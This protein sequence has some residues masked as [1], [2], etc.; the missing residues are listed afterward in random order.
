[1]M[2]QSLQLFLLIILLPFG[3]LFSQSMDIDRLVRLKQRLDVIVQTDTLYGQRL[4][5]SISN[6]G[7]NDFLNTIAKAGEVNL[8]V[9]PDINNPITC[10]FKQIRIIDILF[11]V[12][13]EYDLDV[14]GTGNIISVFR[15]KVPFQ[16]PDLHFVYDSSTHTVSFDFTNAKLVN[17]GR[18]FSEQT[19][20]NLVMPQEIF[21]NSVS[22][23]GKDMKIGDAIQ[24]IATV[25]KLGSHQKNETT[26]SVYPD[27]ENQSSVR[28][29]RRFRA[30][31]LYVDSLKQITAKI[32]NGNIQ[33]IIPEICESL[34]LNYFFT[35][36][37][38]Q[39]TGIYVEKVNFDTFLNVLFTGTGYT[40]REENGIYIFG[41][42]GDNS[43]LS[44]AKVIPMKYRTVEK[45]VDY[46][47]NELKKGIEILTFPDLNSLILSGDHRQILKVYSFLK[48]IDRSVPLI[49]IDVIILDATDNNTREAGLKM[50]L[51]S[52]PSET[53]GSL[54]PGVNFSLSSGS[55]NKLINSFNGFGSINLGKV[56]PNFYM[57][58]KFLEENGKVSIRS[59]PRL[60][61]L[62]GH[63]ATLKS[64]ETKYYK[65]SQTN[66]IGTQN[67]LQSESYQWKSVEANLTL[68]ITPYVSLDSCI[69]MQI[70]LKQSEFQDRDPKEAPPGTSN[71]SFN[72]IIKVRNQEMVLLGGIE[73]NVSSLTTSGLPF[74]A[75]VPIL[76][77]IF[78]SSTK[79]KQ[80]QKLNIFIKPV[81]I[82]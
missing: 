33:S 22:A 29:Y 37:M 2:K 79:K 12:C 26:W 53:S 44:M 48:D 76:R 28:R 19:G 18:A 52:K 64:G 69:T 57:S 58:L 35:E 38:E 71:R 23:F 80:S 45:V 65:E 75:R 41:K 72:S 14:D 34:G 30:D 13:K 70:D 81:I 59:T 5:I 24:T 8:N 10:N 9:S 50:G 1:M 56:T 49:S 67:P 15:Y 20:V 43:A 55:V 32:S 61:T 46:I 68:D 54:S 27:N 77:W 7:V 63:K 62:N 16:E 21:Y 39:T 74:L 25:N 11:F 73:R 51:G 17:V 3:S 40:W 42:A 31:E 36:H 66:I 6:M 78:G 60:S 47:P 82:E 4:D